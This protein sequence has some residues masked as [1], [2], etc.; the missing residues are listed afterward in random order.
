MLRR[1]NDLAILC[2]SAR[3]VSQALQEAE[4]NTLLEGENFE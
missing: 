3:F 4:E 1:E 2:V